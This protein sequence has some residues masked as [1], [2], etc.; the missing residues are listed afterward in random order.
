MDDETDDHGGYEPESETLDETNADKLVTEYF[1]PGKHEPLEL[2]T[3]EGLVGKYE[4]PLHRIMGWMSKDVVEVC[5]AKYKHSMMVGGMTGE[6]AASPW[7][8]MMKNEHGYSER[9]ESKVVRE[10]VLSEADR[11]QLASLGIKVIE[12]VGA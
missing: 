11:A 3:W 4:I 1:S 6:Y 12:D 9:S 10:A 2:R 5:H 7:G 8:L